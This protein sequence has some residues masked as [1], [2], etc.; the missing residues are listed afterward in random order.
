MQ[1]ILI[2]G[3]RSSVIDSCWAQLALPPCCRF[4]GLSMNRTMPS[5][6][7]SCL[8]QLNH[9]SSCTPHRI[10]GVTIYRQF[11]YN[12]S[13]YTLSPLLAP[14]QTKL[15][16]DATDAANPLIG[17]DSPAS[18]IGQSGAVTV[19]ESF[20]PDFP[21]F[22]SICGKQTKFNNSMKPY[23]SYLDVL[24][25]SCI[26]TWYD[27]ACRSDAVFFPCKAVL[28]HEGVSPLLANLQ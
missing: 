1:D 19:C 6:S 13:L 7:L 14:G 17:F 24:L 18:P 2:N 25:S 15:Q 28:G 3:S 5:Y 21:F 11:D 26:G 10:L 20:C 8:M 22:H 27:S 4:L 16:I 23:S 12:Q 9:Q